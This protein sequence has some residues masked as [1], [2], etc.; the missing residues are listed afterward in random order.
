MC[1][2]PVK[3][4]SPEG[5]PRMVSCGKCLECL[6]SISNEWAFRILDECSLYERN[7][8]LTLTYN[9]CNLPSDMSVS[10]RE[11]QLFM[12]S[13]RKALAPR[14]IRFFVSGEYGKKY[15]RP[16]YHYI[17]FGWYPEDAVY[18]KTDRKGVKLYRSAFLESIWRKGF[19]SVGFVTYDTALYAA[20]YL[21]KIQFVGDVPR[22]LI[23]IGDTYDLVDIKPP[24]VLM[25]NRPGIGYGVI[26][27]H[28]SALSTNRIYKAGHFTK[29]PRYYLKVMERDGICLE[30][31]RLMKQAAGN[32][33]A[34]SETAENLK[35]RRRRA[36][37]FLYKKK[38]PR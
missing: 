35:S 15:M 2:Y 37:E 3:V 26:Y 33:R 27:Q 29:I 31:F 21:Q 6:R 30:D 20:K 22:R 13:L 23:D 36:F 11:H 17:I 9:D 16:H 24:F 1:L 34:V 7:S 14:K 32:L 38:H 28:T 4:R 19:S 25:S 10:K 8:F 5:I 18:F 12:K